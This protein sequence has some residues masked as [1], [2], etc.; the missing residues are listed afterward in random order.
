MDDRRILFLDLGPFGGLL[1]NHPVNA[2][3]AFWQDHGLCLLRTILHQA[4]IQTDIASS[5]LCSNWDELWPLL[6][7]YDTLIMNVRSYRFGPAKLVARG[8]KDINPGGIVLVGGMHASVAPEDMEAVEEFDH[9][10]KG[11]GEKV[12]VDLVK[13]PGDFPKLFDGPP[14]LRMEDWPRMDR[15]L[16]PR[17][18]PPSLQAVTYPLEA[19]CGWG[20]PPVATMITSRVCPWRCSFCLT[21]DTVV[22]TIAG[23]KTIKELVDSGADKFDVFSCD[24]K[25]NLA[26]GNAH[27]VKR[28]RIAAPVWRI[29]LDDG[30]NFKATHDHPVMMRDGSYRPVVELRA[31]DSMM[32]FYWQYRPM[33][34]SKNQYLW[35]KTRPEGS[36]V[37]I[38]RWMVRRRG[39]RLTPSLVVHHRNFDS[40]DN[41]TD[42]LE[43]MTRTAHQELHGRLAAKNLA[44]YNRTR[45]YAPSAETRAKIGAAH[46]GMK[47]S[48][49]TCAKVSERKREFWANK[50][51]EERQVLLKWSPE[52][53]AAM[54]AKHKGKKQPAAAIKKTLTGRKAWWDA[55]TP[56]EKREWMK[57]PWAAPKTRNSDGRWGSALHNH[58]IVSVEFAGHE[59]VYDLT[60]DEYHNFAV[61][62]GVFVH[63]CNE[64][65]YIPQM[66]RRSVDS[67]IDEL[68]W[69]DAEYGP[70][71]S[72]VFHDSMLFQNPPWLREFIDKYPKRARK[73]WPYWAAGRADT[74]RKWP[75]LF[76]AL[77]RETNWT[78]VSIGFESGSDRVLEVLNKECTAEDNAFAIDLL[79]E[80]G[81]DLESKGRER[82]RFW[83][84][85]MFA[86]PGER[87]EDAFRTMK[88]WRRMKNPIPTLAY[89]APYA[90]S[91]LGYQ[92]MAEGKSLMEKDDHQRYAGQPKVAGVDYRFYDDLL[93]GRYEREIEATEFP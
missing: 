71:G 23:Q 34:R 29:T 8:F 28:T 2:I 19:S 93:R 53:R 58:K 42:N 20:N 41:R 78:T 1:G 86:V 21:G 80:I 52:K 26:V 18:L 66:E 84:N 14:S 16:W 87:R 11:P 89:Y 39:A 6:V 90:G 60:V 33:G 30:T 17:P 54:S 59:D 13:S 22:H 37:P 83:A 64:A 35:A 5:R 48:A 76:E 72:V 91:A 46:R 31:G 27:S 45:E 74:V 69:L 85:I 65:S 44:E 62:G 47:R 67:L 79:N 70:L 56:E 75:D 38:W 61:A 25:G 15:T 9:V 32:P 68:N 55:K 40:K 88:M 24:E 36:F 57:R 82:P 12:I 63:N 4:G 43:V 50:R 81:D 7:G 73:V 92:L 3:D 77:V 10:C 51:T 49:A